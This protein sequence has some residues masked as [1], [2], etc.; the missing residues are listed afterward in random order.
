MFALQRAGIVNDDISS[1]QLV[2]GH[3]LTLFTEFNFTGTSTAQTASSSCLVGLGFNDS[4]SSL[5]ITSP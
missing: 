2:A 3:T 1:F 5:K 4:V